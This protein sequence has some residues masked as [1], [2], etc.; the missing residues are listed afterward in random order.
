[1]PKFNIEVTEVLSKVITVE[2]NN[3]DEAVEIARCSYDNAE[4]GWVLTA[5]NWI[6][7]NLSFVYKC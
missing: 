7:T 3:E 4:D 6:E 5:D 1:M 2:A